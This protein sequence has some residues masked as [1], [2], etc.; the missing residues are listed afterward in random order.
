MFIYL[1]I[2]PG[3]GVFNNRGEVKENDDPES[4]EKMMKRSGLR[5]ITTEENK[6]EKAIPL[7]VLEG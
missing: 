7:Q 6:G 5:V 4:F 3:A 2:A 1:E